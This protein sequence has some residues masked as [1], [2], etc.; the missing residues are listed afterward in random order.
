MKK[1]LDERSMIEGARE[2][3][4]EEATLNFLKLGIA[5]EVIVKGTELSIERIREIKNLI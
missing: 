3:G 5:E 1:I 2:E 4:K